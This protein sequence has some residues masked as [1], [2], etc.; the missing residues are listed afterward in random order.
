[1]TLSRKYQLNRGLALLIKSSRSGCSK[2][3]PLKVNRIFQFLLEMTSFYFIGTLVVFNAVN[4]GSVSMKSIVRNDSSSFHTVC[5]NSPNVVYDVKCRCS[6]VESGQ[7][8]KKFHVDCSGL[9]LTR[10]PDGIPLNTTILIL[11]NNK[12]SVLHNH[13]FLMK[14]NLVI[15]GLHNAHHGAIFWLW[16]RPGGKVWP[17]MW[18]LNR[19]P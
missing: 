15:L 9:N 1:M 12:I 4:V 19:G 16:D 6:N 18:V 11:D 17:P 10:V 2:Y 5:P 3:K 14:V 13:S 7:N 8:I